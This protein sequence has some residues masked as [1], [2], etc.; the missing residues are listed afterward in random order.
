MRAF[1][2]FL[3]YCHTLVENDNRGQY[4]SYSTYSSTLLAKD[5]MIP[6]QTDSIAVS[7]CR[8]CMHC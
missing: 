3:I 8:V 2:S 4:F 7:H 5:I 6:E 1:V